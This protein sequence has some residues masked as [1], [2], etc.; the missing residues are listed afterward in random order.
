MKQLISKLSRNKKFSDLCDFCTNSADP[1]YIL[2]YPYQYIIH[3]LKTPV[4]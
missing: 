4:I 1:D 3:V 2:C